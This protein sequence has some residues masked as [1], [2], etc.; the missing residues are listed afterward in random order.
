MAR[1]RT[2]ALC[3][4]LCTSVLG[5]ASARAE[6][7]CRFN[8]QG[9]TLRLAA[10]CQ[11]DQT[12]FI[13]AGLTLDGQ[14]HRVRA[15]DP[16]GGSF[17]GAVVRNEGSRANLKRLVIDAGNLLPVCHPTEPED[18][19]MR[20][21]LFMGA[22]GSITD[23]RIVAVNQGESGCQ[24][25]IGIEV[26][27]GDAG[28]R[29]RVLI[30]GNHIQNFQKTGIFVRGSIDVDVHFNYVSGEG[31]VS[32]IAQNGIQLR[33]AVRGE[34]KFNHVSGTIYTGSEVSATGILLNDGASL[35]VSSNHVVDTDVGIRLLSVSGAEVHGNLIAAAT[36]DGV[37][38]D[39]SDGPTTHNRI[40][41]NRIADCE[42][43]IDLFGE[44]ARFN[45][46]TANKIS[47]SGS[48]AIQVVLG[49]SANAVF[50]NETGGDPV[51]DD[52]P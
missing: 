31:P 52:S 46:V 7:T 47:A 20:A 37:T 45:L 4:F 11:T 35:E 25:G 49:A 32:F 40:V 23:N 13:P 21:V 50:G 19:R 43:G 27:A 3:V 8:R 24:E 6:S 17:S 16:P 22:S 34:L 2:S 10:D 15:V 36:Y 38:V 44:G 5:V 18:L 42:V 12:L 1:H 9:D 30:R 33:D 48:A 26:R 14:G 28:E 41:A 51:V 39:G 29:P